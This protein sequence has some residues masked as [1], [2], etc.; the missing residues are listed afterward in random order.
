MEGAREERPTDGRT[1]GR[2]DVEQKN[3]PGEGRE[4]LVGGVESRPQRGVCG[5]RWGRAASP[6]LKP[7]EGA[8]LEAPGGDVGGS[9]TSHGLLW[10]APSH[11]DFRLCPL[12]TPALASFPVLRGRRSEVRGPRAGWTQDS[13]WTPQGRQEALGLPEV[14]AAPLP[15]CTP[16]PE[17]SPLLSSSQPV[18][19]ALG[20]WSWPP[21]PA[22]PPLASSVLAPTPAAFRYHSFRL[23]IFLHFLVSLASIPTVNASCV[24]PGSRQTDRQLD[25]TCQHNWLGER[26]GP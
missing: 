5:R 15:M 25:R 4:V 7:L 24:W 13:Q 21:N 16:V 6:D 10:T 14:R 22:L 26:G 19:L 20:P 3:A 17:G 1:E 9:Q 2:S 18:S 23:T 11:S 12:A 8:E